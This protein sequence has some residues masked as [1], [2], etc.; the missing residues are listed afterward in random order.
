MALTSQEDR[1]SAFN[2]CNGGLDIV[3]PWVDNDVDSRDRMQLWGAYSG[4]SPGP[5]GVGGDAEGLL[6]VMG[7]E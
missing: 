7:A 1:I 5:P 4:N 3:F 2:F 6:P